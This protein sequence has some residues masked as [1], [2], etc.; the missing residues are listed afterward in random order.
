MSIISSILGSISWFIGFLVDAVGIFVI[1]FT[2]AVVIKGLV[3][4]VLRAFGL[5]KKLAMVG[6]EIGF[7]EWFS[8]F[9][10]YLIYFFTLIWLVT[11]LGIGK[12]AVLSFGFI[13]VVL[14]GLSLLAQGKDM[15]LNLL[16]Y[17]RMS[18]KKGD[19]VNVSV[20][21]GRVEKVGFWETQVRTNS[22]DLFYTP[23]SVL[24]SKE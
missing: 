8:N 12:F 18:L 10:S 24:V 7:E 17:F 15:P 16:A 22:G 19:V 2:A 9:V 6:I 14:V 3:R 4:K 21:S 20:I 11:A 13:V 1:G 23:N 5:N